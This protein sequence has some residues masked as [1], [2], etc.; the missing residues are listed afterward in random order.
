M[1]HWVFQQL[2]PSHMRIRPKKDAVIVL[3]LLGIIAAATW[4]RIYQPRIGYAV[5]QNLSYYAYGGYV[6]SHLTATLIISVGTALLGGYI[7]WIIM[8]DWERIKARFKR[9]NWK[10]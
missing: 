5:A 3:L 4:I 9:R 2:S 10:P 7:S 8:K 1:P 6:D